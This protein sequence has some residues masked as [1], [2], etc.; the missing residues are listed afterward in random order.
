[1][2][3]L[4][5][6]EQTHSEVLPQPR[7]L[8]STSVDKLSGEHETGRGGRQL[9]ATGVQHGRG[10][11]ASDITWSQSRHPEPA[12]AGTGAGREAHRTEP[13][14]LVV[15]KHHRPLQPTSPVRARK[16]LAAGRAR[17]HRYSP[18]VIRL[19]DRTVEESAV[20]GVELGVD[21]GSR[22]TGV[23]VFTDTN[24]SRRGLLALE[25]SHRGI[26]ISRRIAGRAAS[27]TRRRS[28]N[29]R[30]RP[31]RFHNRRRTEGWLAPSLR[32]RVE[33]TASWVNRLTRWAPVAGIHVETAAFDAA[34]VQNPDISG[35]EYQHGTLHGYE[36]R[37]YLLEK[38]NRRCAYC[39]VKGVPLNIEHV[40][41]RARG[42]SDRISNLAVACIPC[43]QSKGTSDVATF[44]AD[45]PA[46][47]ARIKRQLKSPL[48]DAAAVSIT[49]PRLVVELLRIGV[50]VTTSTGGRTKFNRHT[51]GAPKSHTLDALHVGVMSG[52]SG[53]P[54]RVL[55]LRCTSRG[56]YRRT[57]SDAQGFPRL[58]FTR[59]KTAFGYATGDLVRAVVPKG[60]W[61]GTHVG[62]VAIRTSGSFNI[63]T[64]AGLVTNINCRHFRLLQRADGYSHSWKEEGAA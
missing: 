30:Y 17:I 50:S 46:V 37:Q 6:S 31:A 57:R 61:R 24:E 36:V 4:Y 12:L 32:H 5:V 34:L 43:N 64:P 23:S 10:E 29:L 58:V 60:K 27:R 49:S 7:T 14:V 40:H 53:Y 33:T 62:R 44:L 41:P 52:C 54:A 22:Y 42:G 38:W 16:L 25:I 63:S 39:G 51:S 2:A 56:D 35:V 9:A 18:F 8:E 26:A 19:V 21:P 1:M 20:A 3:T 48:R 55:A 11:T 59:S 13:A 47:L 45:R 15:D 28:A